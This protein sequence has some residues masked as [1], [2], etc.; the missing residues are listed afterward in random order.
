MLWIGQIVLLIYLIENGG[1]FK[2]I[3][4]FLGVN[5]L[6]GIVMLFIYRDRWEYIKDSIMFGIR[7]VEL[8]LWGH[9]WDKPD[10]KDK[11]KGKGIL[12]FPD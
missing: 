12:P 11:K 2:G 8:I 1:I 6:V 7:S 3:V 4:S 9:T 5:L 10:K